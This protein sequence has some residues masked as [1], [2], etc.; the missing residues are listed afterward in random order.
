MSVA[1]K[2][3]F[4]LLGNDAEDDTPQAPVKTVEKNS[5]RS[6]KRGVEPEA[7]SRAP[8]AGGAR[9]NNASGNEADLDPLTRLLPP[10]AFRDRGAGSDRNRGK[11]TDEP[12]RGGPRGGYGARARGGRGGRFPRERDD[13]Q[14]K[15]LASGSEK[16]AAQSWG[17][18]EGEAERKDEVAGEAIAQA[19]AK[20]AEAEAAA[21]LEPEEPEEKQV[22]YTEYLAQLA[23]KKLAIEGNNK[24]REANEGTKLKKEWASAKEVSRDEDENFMI[25]TGGKTKR[26][27]ERKTKQLLDIDQRYVEPERSSRGGA[28]G[29][30]GGRGG[31]RGGARGGDRGDRGG[32]GR[33]DGARGAPRGGAPRGGRPQ[34]AQINTKDES[35]FPSLGGK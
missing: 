10:I 26:E 9:R 7:P 12:A 15:G 14:S 27:R 11:T 19:E 24:V 32:R 2:N 17:A 23:E 20:D 30:R 34:G 31:P 1:S 28:G 35:A 25:G 21:P 18:T 4:E 16:Q 8:A 3:L 5:L 6:T 13:R 22:S 29:P 33:G